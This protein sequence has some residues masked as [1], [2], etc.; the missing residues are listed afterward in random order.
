MILVA[1]D[2]MLDR[3]WYGEVNRISP[4]A[5][6]PVVAVKGSEERAGAAANVAVNIHAMGGEVRRVFSP[7]FQDKPIVKL[8]I[9]SGS[10]HVV[11][12]DFDHPQ[13]PISVPEFEK[14]LNGCEILVISD[15]G[16]GALKYIEEM[17]AIARDARVRILVDPK[18][19][20]Y[21]KYA[22]AD[23][24]KPNTDEL[25]VI[26]GGWESEDELEHKVNAM[27]ERAKINTVL[28]TRGA[29]GMT[30]F[31]GHRTNIAPMARE[32]VDVSG[33]GEAAIS[34]LAVCFAQGMDAHEAS[35]FANKAAGLA[36]GKFGTTV[37]S[38]EDVFGSPA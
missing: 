13:E 5:P 25:R 15:Y 33:A 18:G 20:R 28:L 14:A 17:V 31:N 24:V 2:A 36:C 1:G 21:A 7:S 11:R 9:V 27:R 35:I 26:I 30:I 3:Y 10:H 6:V 32:V 34:A 37:L 12:I 22:G 4:E 29:G 38:R 8:R 16:K 19:Y 23:V